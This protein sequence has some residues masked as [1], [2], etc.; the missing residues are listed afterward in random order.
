MGDRNWLGFSGRVPRT[1]PV[2][3]TERLR[4]FT[5]DLH[6]AAQHSDHNRRESQPHRIPRLSR[7]SSYIGLGGSG[8]QHSPPRMLVSLD[9][10][11]P[12]KTCNGFSNVVSRININTRDGDVHDCYV[13]WHNPNLTQIL[14]TV[15]CTIMSSKPP[16]HLHLK[17][18]GAHQNP[19]ESVLIAR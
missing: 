2:D 1:E 17:N 18:P 4:A 12:T 8:K 9:H 3:D 14:E 7:I 11:D 16:S 5:A 13:T 15:S 19:L 6:N 10:D